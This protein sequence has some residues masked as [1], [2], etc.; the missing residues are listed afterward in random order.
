MFFYYRNRLT[1]IEPSTW[2]YYRNRLT[3]GPDTMI[4]VTITFTFSSFSLIQIFCFCDYIKGQS[5][6][7]RGFKS[8][9]LKR[10][11][12]FRSVH[13]P[14]WV[15]IPKYNHP[16][17]SKLQNTGTSIIWA[18][19]W[20]CTS[21]QYSYIMCSFFQASFLYCKL[22]KTKHIIDQKLWEP[23]D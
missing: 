10:K 22:I 3:K 20:N 7:H 21:H 23:I 14:P 13:L 11:L 18:A 9:S 12:S 6:T 5:D 19:S 2:F 4:Y 1:R 16:Y 8:I 17:S 15:L